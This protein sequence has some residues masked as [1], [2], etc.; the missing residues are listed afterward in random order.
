MHEEISELLEKGAIKKVERAQEEFL[1][2]LF[3]A[4]KKDRGNR[5]VIFLKKLNT[6]NLYEHFKV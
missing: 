1:S 5:S 4:G 3:L 6:F 2:N